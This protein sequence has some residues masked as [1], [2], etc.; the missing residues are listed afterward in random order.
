MGIGVML[1]TEENVTAIWFASISLG[2]PNIQSV[3]YNCKAGLICF[4]TFCFIV[5]LASLLCYI[6]V[7]S[8]CTFLQTQVL[9]SYHY[10]IV[11]FLYLYFYWLRNPGRLFSLPTIFNILPYLQITLTKFSYPLFLHQIFNLFIVTIFFL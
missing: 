10:C 2:L 1:S 9:C 7:I 8:L 4:S 5:F 6:R 11:G 3:Q